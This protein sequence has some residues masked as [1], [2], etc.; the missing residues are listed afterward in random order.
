MGSGAHPPSPSYSGAL[1]KKSISDFHH[2]MTA[3]SSNSRHDFITNF[4]HK[5][6]LSSSRHAGE[7]TGSDDD[8]GGSCTPGPSNSSHTTLVESPSVAEPASFF[9]DVVRQRYLS[10]SCIPVDTQSLEATF[11][12]QMG[13]N[14]LLPPKNDYDLE[15]SVN[16]TIFKPGKSEYLIFR[17]QGEIGVCNAG[18]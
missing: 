13:E 16:V 10:S 11:H 2:N 17:S 1:A 14:V 4:V 12:S 5:L 7:K 18:C 6:S 3:T 9:S 15:P 8:L